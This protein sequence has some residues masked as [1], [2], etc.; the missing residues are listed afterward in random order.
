MGLRLNA[1]KFLFTAGLVWLFSG[2]LLSESKIIKGRVLDKET[3][4]PVNMAFVMVEGRNTGTT[5]FEDGSFEISGYEEKRDKY[6]LIYCE[7]YKPLRVPIIP[8]KFLK[9]VLQPQIFSYEITVVAKSGIAEEEKEGGVIDKMDVYNIPGTAA[10]PILTANLLPG[11][12]SPPDTSNLLIRGGAPTEVG[13]YY[14]GNEI[15]HPFQLESSRANYFSVFDNQI[16]EKFDVVNSGFSPRFGDCLSGVVDI[17][18]RDEIYTK[19]GGLGLSVS[20]FSGYYAV[21]LGKKYGLNLSGKGDFSALLSKLNNTENIDFRNFNQMGNVYFKQNENSKLKLSWLFNN[22]KFG[23]T[24]TFNSESRNFVLI[25]SYSTVIKSILWSKISLSYVDYKNN[26][27]VP[28]DDFFK[29]FYETAPQFRI[30]NTLVLGNNEIKFGA[31]FMKRKEKV[32]VAGYTDEWLAE[33]DRYGVY[34]SGRYRITNRLLTNPGIRGNLLKVNGRKIFSFDP[35]FSIAYI[36]NKKNIFRFSTGLYHQY[37]DIFS[38]YSINNLEAKSS[39]HMSL[40][41]DYLS[42]KDFFRLS[43]YNKEYRNLFLNEPELT[44]NGRGYARG[45]EIYY[46][47]TNPKFDLMVLYN[48]LDSKRKEDDIV[49]LVDSKYEATHSATVVLAWK[50]KDYS[51]GIR[52]SYATGLPF[53]PVDYAVYNEEEDSYLPIFGE[54]NSV[55][56]RNFVRIDLNG[57]KMWKTKKRLIILYFGIIN[58]FNRKNIQNYE[59]NS[60]TGMMEPIYSIFKRSVHVG[61]YCTL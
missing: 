44:D 43:I 12:T 53:T 7:N 49:E 21:P 17:K 1:K 34:L 51:L 58:I 18:P 19:E 15:L 57:K 47:K 54:S 48:Y 39:F 28:T 24:D 13:Y 29:T 32:I 6:L 52:A 16:I 14:D 37:G 33:A 4:L 22:Y 25:G 2:F 41:Y 45:F 56:A 26:I 5:V 10:D 11:V 42:D 23:Q 50:H 46:K 9:I 35:R 59:Y 55:R 31:E 60:S 40:S 3:G 8:G 61:F 20:G 36:L 38:Y 27:E 30:D